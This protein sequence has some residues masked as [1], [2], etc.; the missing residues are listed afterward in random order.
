VTPVDDPLLATASLLPDLTAGDSEAACTPGEL[1]A[2]LRA[3]ELDIAILDLRRDLCKQEQLV[4]EWQFCLRE[5]KESVLPH[6]WTEEDRREERELRAG[7]KTAQEAVAEMRR[8][9]E[10]LESQRRVSPEP[11]N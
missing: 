3:I 8:R 5:D 4:E 9:L 10:R 1:E 6:E 7:L 11:E 2:E